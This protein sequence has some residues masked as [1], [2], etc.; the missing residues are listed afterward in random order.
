MPLATSRQF[1]HALL[2]GTLCVLGATGSAQVVVVGSHS[3][4]AALSKEQVADAF[5]G[6]MVGVEPVDQAE[7]DPIR[8]AFYRKLTGKSA[9]QLKAYRARLEFTGRAAPPRQ[10]PNAAGV[11]RHLSGSTMAISYL[12]KA[13]V[14]SS[15][16]VVYEGD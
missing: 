2:A 16:K 9:A 5:L 1:H 4:L 14:D 10:Y 8:E 7:G 13:D 11:K 15:V 6:R 12:E 3:P